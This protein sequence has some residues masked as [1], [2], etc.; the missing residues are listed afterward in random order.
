MK[1]S[2]HR[3]DIDIFNVPYR[4][5]RPYQERIADYYRDGRPRFEWEKI[6]Q[7]MVL[8]GDDTVEVVCAPC[9]LNLMQTVEGCGIVVEGLTTFMGVM[10][11]A[12]PDS[13]LVRY[14]YSDDVL[15]SDDA[16]LL[17]REL[18]KLTP[19]LETMRWPVAQMFDRNGEPRMEEGN[20]ERYAMI[21]WEGGEA[22]TFIFSNA[23]YT[24]AVGESGIIV[25]ESLGDAPPQRFKRLVKVGANV[26][27]ETVDGQEL[28]FRPVEECTPA[29][30]TGPVFGFGELR[31]VE[32][33]LWE[34]FRD[35]VESL[36]VFSSVAMQHN[37]G[38]KIALAT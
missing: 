4:N 24:V 25:R 30:E 36:L 5:C 8:R 13:M 20:V 18:E 37:T 17:H 38:L 26:Y 14:S 27:G 32:M 35:V 6:K 15:T 16:R 9:P 22:E 28:P 2:Q 23:G 11:H 1:R 10:S 31:F 34:I 33:S 19:L 29:W 12:K 3:V 21:E 7:N